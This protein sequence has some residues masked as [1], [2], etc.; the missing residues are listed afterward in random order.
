MPVQLEV[1]EGDITTVPVDAV[2]A[3]ANAA[4][5]G[6]GG[7]DGAI[8]AAAGPELL[9]ALREGWPDGIETGQAVVTPAYRMTSARWVIHAVGPIWR[10]GGSGEA[11]LL[12]SSYVDSLA[13]GD[14]VGAESVAFPAISTGIYGYPKDQAARIAVRTLLSTPTRVERAVLVAYD[15]ATADRYRALL[16]S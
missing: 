2:V 12:A 3:A 7:V 1:V 10:G 14:D 11:E 4:L 9:A 8:H 15:G 6:G 13:R 5:A 16:F